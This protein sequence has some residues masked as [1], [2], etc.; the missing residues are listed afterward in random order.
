MLSIRENG[1]LV[2]NMDSER[3]SGLTGPNSK[4]SGKMIKR[5]LE[6]LQTE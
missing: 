4:D 2:G 5:N 1:N 3:C 6:N